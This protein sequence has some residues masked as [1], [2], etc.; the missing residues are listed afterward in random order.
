VPPLIP[1]GFD[2]RRV[3]VFGNTHVRFAPRG[4]AVTR[5]PG[6]YRGRHRAIRPAT[7]WQVLLAWVWDERV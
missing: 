4:G 3:D 6:S 1:F 2:V 7:R 5:D